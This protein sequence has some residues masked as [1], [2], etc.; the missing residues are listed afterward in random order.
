MKIAFIGLGKMGRPMV[1]RLL[2]AGHAVVVHNRSRAAVDGA[3][4]EGA[5][6]ASSA[7]DAA[8][9]ADVVMTAL[10][11]LDTVRSIYDELANVA[12]PGQIFIE[13]ST[14]DPATGRAC[15]EVVGRNG[16]DYLD[17]PVSGGPEGAREGSLTVMVGGDAEV[18][19]RARVALQAFAGTVRLCGHVGAGQAVKLVNQLLVGVH[20]AASAEAFAFGTALGATPD[21][22][23]ELVGQS[24]GA[25]RMLAR[26][27]PRFAG[28]DFTATTSVGILCKDLSIILDQARRAGTPLL[29]GALA[30]QRFLEAHSRGWSE[31]DMSV[32]VR[33]WEKGTRHAGT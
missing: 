21:A 14:V 1:S 32:L 18:L 22:I 15:A 33:L 17:A 9:Q 7:S 25:S 31:E 23:A 27:L 19:N 4:A 5:S 11:T 12:R 8:D 13:H 3:V 16:A 20:T 2:L 30:D 26:N 28:R 6:S 10:P 29:L 24:F